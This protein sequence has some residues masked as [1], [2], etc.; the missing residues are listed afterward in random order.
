MRHRGQPP[1]HRGHIRAATGLDVLRRGAWFAGT[2]HRRARRSPFAR[3]L[4]EPV[5][6]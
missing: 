4:A 3:L 5:A 6:A 2:P 1:V